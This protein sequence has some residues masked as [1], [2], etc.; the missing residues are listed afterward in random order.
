MIENG[1]ETPLSR[2][3]PKRVC[4]VLAALLVLIAVRACAELMREPG[5]TAAQTELTQTDITA[6]CQQ[7]E[8]GTELTQEQQNLLMEQTGLGQPGLDAVLEH[9]DGDYLLQCQQAWFAQPETECIDNGL[10]S[11]EEL[12]VD[13]RQPQPYDL[14]TGDIL[15]SFNSHTVGYRH[16]HAALVVDGNRGVTLEAATMGTDSMI[17]SA[18]HWRD[19]PSFVQLRLKEDSYHTQAVGQQAADTALEHLS[20]IPYDLFC[21]F[22]PPSLPVDPPQ[23]VQC[24]SLVW[25]AYALAGVDLHLNGIMASPTTLINSP[26]LEVVQAF[27][28]E[29]LE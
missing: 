11:S 1:E 6:L 8:A 5:M 13:T 25:Y 18:S 15:V 9:R 29:Y 19:Y 14:Q 23:A 27:G 12:L 4:L 7:V 2:R 26:E 28:G 3:W 10:T 20:G 16:G 21:G 24:A 22:F 17:L